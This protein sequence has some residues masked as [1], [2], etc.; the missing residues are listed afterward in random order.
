MFF[1]SKKKYEINQA[2]LSIVHYYCEC[3]YE[4]LTFLEF[5]TCIIPNSQS[6]IPYQNHNLSQKKSLIQKL[7]FIYRKEMGN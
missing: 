3:H 1:F 6:E 5:K 7:F 2:N 4:H